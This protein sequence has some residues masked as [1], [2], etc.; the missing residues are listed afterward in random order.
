VARR[1]NQQAP[2]GGA[3]EAEGLIHLGRLD[4]KKI[5]SKTVIT[6]ESIERLIAESRAA[7]MTGS[8]QRFV[9]TPD[10]R[11][12][13][14][15]R[16]TDLLDAL[17]IDWRRAKPHIRCPYQDHDDN[18]PSWRWDE[19]KRKAFCTCGV[20]DALEVLMGVEGIEFD[21]AKI[22]AAELL[23]RP[24]LIRERRGRKR[25]GGG[26]AGCTLAGYA[27]AKR[28]PIEFLRSLGLTEITYLGA[29]A[30]RIPYYGV[31]GG[32]AAV[33]FRTTL[34]KAAPNRFRW[35]RGAKVCLYGLSR[36]VDAR[37]VGFAVLVEGESDCH[38][39]W[40]HGFSAIGLP[41]NTNWNELRDA[42]LLAEIPTI[43]VAIEPD[44]GGET[45][46]KW[47]RN[48]SIAPRA[49]LVRMKSAKDA[50]A[51]YLADPDGFAAA[52]QRELDDA[53]PF[54]AIRKREASAEFAQ[55]AAVAGDLIREPDLLSR[56]AVDISRAGL[57]GEV[58]N[59]KVLYLVQTTRLFDRPVN[60]AVKGPSSAGKNFT[61]KKVTRFFPNEAY[62]S[63]TSMSDRTLAY[64]EEDFRHRH[65]VLYEA[66]G[67]TSDIA[68]YLMRSLLSEGCIDYE[69]VEKTKDGMRPRVI[70]KEGPTGLITTT[71][72]AGLHPENETRLLS[73]T[74]TDTPEQTRAVML[75]Q[76]DEADDDTADYEPWRAY[77]RWLALGE[78]RVVVPFA[79]ALVF[80]IPALAVRLRRDF[81]TL[82]SLIRA[83][84][85]LHRELAR[86]MSAAGSS[87]ALLTTPPSAS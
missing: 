51:L 80:E 61:V 75:A 37:K 66:A 87:R 10:I 77:Q 64:S 76:A 20:R 47:L 53:E 86:E 22:R 8:D 40:L 38:T 13:V 28:L 4:A 56:F 27:Q 79:R 83:H 34:E 42:P 3:A 15:G 73:L 72:A 14:R 1:G 36:L 9:M 18:N 35:R 31:S 43:Y 74:I 21:A 16:E 62:W 5:G 50:S 60:A 19:R 41:G 2:Q 59:A 30:I 54:C 39:L 69:V 49:K 57:A 6:A 23:N 44:K 24:D 82:L 11:A 58:R 32:E 33:R 25:K 17:N 12:A 29:P 26:G 52:F 70:R 67:M 84:A 63:R 71:T 48:S 68:T 46:M 78:R 85:L 45:V 65:L 55:A 7:A 81:P